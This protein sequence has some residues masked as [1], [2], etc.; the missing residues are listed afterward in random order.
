MHNPEG[1]A[2]AEVRMFIEAKGCT[3]VNWKVENVCTRRI[4]RTGSE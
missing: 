1:R 4:R 2:F 3:E